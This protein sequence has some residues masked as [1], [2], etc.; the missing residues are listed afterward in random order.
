MDLHRALIDIV[1]RDEGFVMK[2]QRVRRLRLDAA[3]IG[4]GAIRN[5]VWDALHDV[6]DPHPSSDVDVVYFDHM[7]ITV[8][9]DRAIERR[10][11]ELD[12]T[13]PWEVTNQAGVHRWFEAMYGHP[14]TPLR[15]IDEAVASW[16]EFA[17]CTAVYIDD[18][19]RIRVIA[20][21]GL[22]DLFSTTVRRNPTRVSVATYR[23]RIASKR[24]AERW[25][26]V[27]IIDEAD[28]SPASSVVVSAT[29][30]SLEESPDS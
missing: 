5:L 2:L 14:V 19:A 20:P 11:Y 15:T 29:S 3:C 10:L 22:D 9:R 13:T 28:A 12:P 26:S 7:D 8:E 25:P 6:R 16:P 30:S 24:Y 21:H 27:R 18:A 1:L 23:E 17:T 4:A